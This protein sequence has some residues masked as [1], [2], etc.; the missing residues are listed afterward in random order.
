MKLLLGSSSFPLIQRVNELNNRITDAG[1]VQSSFPLIQGLSA[2]YFPN[3]VALYTTV[4]S[5]PLIQGSM[6][7]GY[8]KS[9]RIAN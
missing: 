2:A 9:V 1:L 6:S 8:R 3:N 4:S 7:S 5:S